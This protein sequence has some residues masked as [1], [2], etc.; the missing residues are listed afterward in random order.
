MNARFGTVLNVHRNGIL[1][2][3]HGMNGFDTNNLKYVPANQHWM[4][5]NTLVWSCRS[6]NIT[7]GAT[8]LFQNLILPASTL[9]LLKLSAI[10]KQHHKINWEWGMVRGYIQSLSCTHSKPRL[11]KLELCARPI[12]C[13]GTQRGCWFCP[14]GGLALVA[15]LSHP[16]CRKRLH[17]CNNPCYIG[18][19][20]RCMSEKFLLN[21]KWISIRIC[22]PLPCRIMTSPRPELFI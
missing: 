1:K 22:S 10:L 7:G 13:L 9:C 15:A 19:Q 5:Q 4:H 11:D 18:Y 8:H 20:R 2:I 6:P 21:W 16:Q 17:I 14:N 3:S 12:A